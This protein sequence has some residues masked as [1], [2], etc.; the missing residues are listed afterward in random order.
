MSN[1]SR[2]S[3]SLRPAA[4]A[5]FGALL[6]GLA[7]TFAVAWALS[8][9]IH[10]E[11]RARFD[12]TV[13]RIEL[14]VERR[15]N[16]ASYGLRGLA[17]TYASFGDL[18]IDTF[19]DWVA[20]RD[21]EREFPGVRG[22]GIIRRVERADLNA[23]V[24][25]M[26][27]ADP[28][29]QLKTSGQLPDL[30][31]ASQV[32]PKPANFVAWG[33]D[34]GQEPVRRETLERAVATGQ[35]ALTDRASLLQDVKRRAGWLMVLPVFRR[36]E[37]PRSE[38]GRRRSLV[39][40]LYAPIVAADVLADV[41]R[42]FGSQV[43][44]RLYDGP[45][46]DGQLLFDS[47]DD[48]QQG[49]ST[50]ARGGWDRRKMRASRTIEMG[51][52]L[53]TLDLASSA[54]MDASSGE[55]TLPLLVAL[56][57]LLL[58]ALL[59]LS[60]WQLASG[61]RRAEALAN[62]MTADLKEITQ[63]LRA[64]EAFLEQAQRIANVGGWA[65]N[66]EPLALRLSNQT[67]RLVDLPA[68]STH[69]IEQFIDLFVPQSR[70]MIER[71][72]QEAVRDGTPWDL[73]LN[74]VSAKGVS[75][76]VRTVGHVERQGERSVR[77]IGTLQDISDLK[78]AQE[79]LQA[80][81]QFM[82]VVTDN[83][84]GRVG[85]W[86]RNQRCVFANRVYG[87]TF[88]KTQEQMIGYTLPEV[89]GEERYREFLPNIEAV[90]AGKSMSF[91]REETN[92]AGIRRTMLVHYIADIR[93]DETKGF[94]V[95]ALDVTEQKE[96]RDA[97]RQAVAAKGQF[98]AN[99][100]HELRTPM[101]AIIGMLALLR[102]TGLSPRQLDYTEKADGAARS[103]LGLL[104]DIL[105]FSKAD[106]GKLELVPSPFL[107]EVLMRDVSVIL[108]ANLHSEHVEILF[109]IDSAV[110]PALIADDMR[111]RQVLINLGGNAV[112]FTERGEVVIGV[113]L[114]ERT[115][116]H[117]RLEF[118][119][120]DTGIGIA[121][122]QQSRIFEGFQQAEAS[123][124]RKYG[125]TGLGLAISQHLVRLMGSQL[126]LDS[127]LGHGSRFHFTLD[128][129]VDTSK[130]A[131][132]TPLRTTKEVRALFVD[133]NK[134]ALQT[135]S[136]LAASLGW[137][138]DTAQGAEQALE[139]IEA[140]GTPYDA[141]FLDWH[142]PGIDGLQASELMRRLPKVGQSA[143]LIMVSGKARA[144]FAALADGER[145]NLDGYL[146]KPVT[147]SML[148][149]AIDHATQERSGAP[150]EPAPGNQALAGLRLLV[151]EDN[152]NNQQV[153][154]ELLASRGAV[155]DIASDGRQA[156]D[157]VITDPA[158]Y[159]LV[160]MD[161]QMPVMDGY[162]A[163]REIRRAGV[164]SLPI[165]AMTANAMAGDREACIAA[166]MQ[167]HVGK[168]F[169][170]DVLVSTVLKYIGTPGRGAPALV[171]TPPAGGEVDLQSAVQR[172]GGDLGFYRRLYPSIQAD[173]AAML[174]CLEQLVARGE[175]QEA[176]RLFHT[177]KG[178]AG[179][180]GATRLAGAAAQAEQAMSDGAKSTANSSSTG[181][182]SD[183]AAL[184]AATREAYAAACSRIDDE[185]SRL[186]P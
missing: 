80:S 35:L 13:R 125:G 178:L 29:F 17:A 100:S 16:R 78:R 165:V 168:P 129:L 123:T 70:E 53:L 69:T 102:N 74:L 71:A 107:L 86:D 54:E 91:E 117:A 38:A 3:G 63:D 2:P 27:T 40:L 55:T 142:M 45:V 96:A 84:P 44:F 138:A 108:S 10:A 64:S 124:V 141:I 52:Q 20:A 58:S 12:G 42:T 130:R 148:R 31:V 89:L 77:L 155:V 93:D 65:V 6:L 135:L 48:P 23:F 147:A 134:I 106:A 152:L 19:R 176:G 97:A 66:L 28:D 160:L 128:M 136:A 167:D 60:V 120:K 47:A 132:Q 94:F 180:L 150:V 115:G 21:L 181:V 183:G 112:K 87:E 104:N 145:N 101:N 126:E 169:D 109:D 34:L 185:L 73:E 76:W 149:D 114:V 119:V 25:R 116:D 137:I 85:Y 103:L 156:L 57:G 18:S 105:D 81:E 62:A 173:A 15:I 153:A 118:S 5:A 7:V 111:L 177:L 72:T 174:T 122:E 159:D 59:A 4:L 61:R 26:R 33:F 127:A 162:T 164:T 95:L 41:R 146:V 49:L 24:A 143:L 154:R 14:D 39:G 131:A 186:P 170:L 82:R 51:G 157:R 88:G 43:D 79:A 11:E 172:L 30:F 161:V 56:A 163:T 90:L 133:D 184:L 158:A 36:G 68:D 175:R 50:G 144:R 99:T 140:A 151:V 113:R 32:E 182:S 171:G 67:L 121:P 37:D 110:P 139:V 9:S 92:A 179:T 1:A 166:G 22:F 83:L 75:R 8:T 46:A 98:L